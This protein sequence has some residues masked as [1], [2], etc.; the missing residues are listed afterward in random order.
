MG[1]ESDQLL[2][3][4]AE[5]RKNAAVKMVQA[6]TDENY[7]NLAESDENERQKR[8]QELRDAANDVKKAREYLLKTAMLADRI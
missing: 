3:E 4:Y 7:K 8:N 2:N 6:T 1:G 5:T